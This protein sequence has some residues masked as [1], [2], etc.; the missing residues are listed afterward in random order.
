M[1]VESICDTLVTDLIFPEYK[2]N[3]KRAKDLPV[4]DVGK[5]GKKSVFLPAELCEV[6]P[7]QM[8]KGKLSPDATREMIKVASN[9]PALN[10]SCIED[11]GLKLLGLRANTS[12][13]GKIGL[14]VNPDMI[15]VPARILVAPKVTYKSG[16][17][18]VK[19]ASWNILNV[20]FHEPA[21]MS[22]W[23]VLMVQ[24]GRRGE[25]SGPD[26]PAFK[27]FVNAFSKKCRDS[28]LTVGVPT[29]FATTRL[30]PKQDSGR[31]NA[32]AT[33]RSTLEK[34]VN[35]S[36]KQ[37]KPKFVL[38]LLSGEDDFIYPGIK[39]M[40]DMQMGLLTVCMLLTP[41]KARVDDPKKQDQYFSNVA[42]KVNAK[43]GGSNHLL[44]DDTTQRWLTQKRTMLV[45]I[46][47]THP[48]PT[49]A[50]GTPSIVAVVGSVDHSF[51][52]FPVSMGLQR[53]RDVNKNAEEVR[54]LSCTMRRMLTSVLARWYKS[55]AS[56]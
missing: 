51:V 39:R 38:V 52:Q 41:K 32:L 45:G 50:K 31:R 35:V 5:R 23:A 18:Q 34:S 13:L 37:L 33:I 3:L 49:S 55:S 12:T 11:E 21:D 4:I 30:N 56:C 22:R 17:P 48:S 20:K 42:L 46:D 19:D 27:L 9:G 43:L 1:S 6:L 53:N 7:N 10:R 25:F 8:F 15:A 2:I 44:A 14:E 36:S 16:S 29:V 47:V 28:G 54:Q 26:D 24:E 40:C